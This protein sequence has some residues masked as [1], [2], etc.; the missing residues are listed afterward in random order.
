MEDV[1]KDLANGEIPSEKIAKLVADG[2]YSGCSNAT[3]KY[4]EN[5]MNK[6][7]KFKDKKYLQ[8]FIRNLVN[9][10]KELCVIY[11]FKKKILKHH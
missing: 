3:L 8:E 11:F 10:H 9:F 6:N 4:I 7:G 5:L 1:A 2:I